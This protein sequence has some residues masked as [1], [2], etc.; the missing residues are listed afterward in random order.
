[1]VTAEEQSAGGDPWQEVRQHV[2]LEAARRLK[3]LGVTPTPEDLDRE[4]SPPPS[5][6]GDLALPLFRYAKKAATTP[7]KLAEALAVDFPKGTALADVSPTRG[8]LNFTAGVPWLA[9]ATL[10]RILS[11]KEGYARAPPT[12]G[13]VCVEHTSANPTGQLHVGRSR[14]SVIGD[15]YARVL[16]AAG[17]TVR[18]HFYVDDVGR[19]AAT[20]VWIWS[21][22]VA[23]WPS[24]VREKSGISPGTS[25]PEGMKP[26]TWRGKPYPSA[27]EIVKKDAAALQEVTQLTA[28][29]E[30]G[31]IPPQEYRQIPQEILTG[32]V[33]SLERMGVHFD[34]F[35]WE[36]DFIL[37]GSVATAIE[38]LS[39]TP[40]A[41]QEEGGA[42]AVDASS[43][44]LP[45]DLSK[46]LLTRSDGSHLYI[47]RDV[48]YHLEKLSHFDRV[49]DVIGE[50]HKMHF[51]ALLALLA[52]LGLTKKPEVLH[53]AF[54]GLPAGTL[55]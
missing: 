49:V 15:T 40:H 24:E 13:T 31:E 14:N 11:L 17:Y 38:K 19:Q 51:R 37:N 6:L 7:E 20:L 12:R 8:F 22:P 26:D 43:Y 53:Y 4:L 52:E 42:T 2:L 34:D 33:A 32:V 54:I 16:S 46:I 30:R 3:D 36:S 21:K 45:K 35:V 18:V 5:G 50:D 10:G 55:S 44:G 28:R 41:T 48:A 27:S 25:R 39:K 29:L 47:A 9:E 1:M 23:E